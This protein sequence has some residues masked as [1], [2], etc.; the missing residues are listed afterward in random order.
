MVKDILR[1]LLAAIFIGSGL[2]HFILPATYTQAMP[3]WLP[4]QYEL[5]LF[6]GL[7]ELAG[8]LGL[9]VVRFRRYA[10]WLIIG[11]L[12]S[13]LAVHIEHIRNG[14]QVT[15]EISLPVSVLWM[16]LAF[17]AVFIAWANWVGG[18]DTK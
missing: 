5:V 18:S 13:F 15:E 10:A 11:L 4:F 16:R 3:Q 14:G 9:L 6:S 8:G 17:Q 2:F 1:K 12:L 7:L